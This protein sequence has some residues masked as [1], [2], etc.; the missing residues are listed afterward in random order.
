MYRILTSCIIGLTL[1]AGGLTATADTKGKGKIAS[2]VSG[3]L[4]KASG[5]KV[6]AFK[7]DA[8]PSYY[9]AYHSASW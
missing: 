7:S 9:L 6:D 4:V 3:K 2:A 8:S 1:A 5:K